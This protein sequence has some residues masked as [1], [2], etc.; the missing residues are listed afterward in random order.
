[1]DATIKYTNQTEIAQ[2]I[3]EKIESD[4][5]E[6]EG[7]TLNLSIEDLMV[8]IIEVLGEEAF[9]EYWMLHIKENDPDEP[10]QN[11]WAFMNDAENR[12]EG[13][14]E[15]MTKKTRKT[16]QKKKICVVSI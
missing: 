2:A 1:M 5:N 10:N 16:I 8:F 6:I 15:Y 7:A 3:E 12:N 11:K 9:P 4:Y 13:I 14:I